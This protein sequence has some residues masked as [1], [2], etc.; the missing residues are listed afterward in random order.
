MLDSISEVS[1]VKKLGILI[2]LIDAINIVYLFGGSL[3]LKCTAK[4]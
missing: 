3:Y 1:I 2:H 4:I